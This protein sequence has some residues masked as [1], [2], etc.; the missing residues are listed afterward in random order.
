LRFFEML[1]L[2]GMVEKGKGIDE[3]MRAIFSF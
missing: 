2:G 1:A 3:K